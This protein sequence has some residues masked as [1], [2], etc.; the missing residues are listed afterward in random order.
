MRVRRKISRRLANYL[1]DTRI[2]KRITQT[3]LAK[4]SGYK[5]GQT[6]CAIESGRI[7]PEPQALAAYVHFCGASFDRI[8]ELQT[9]HLEDQLREDISEQIKFYQ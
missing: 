3:D 1:G 5:K 7:H 4:W 9:S 2:R 8:L 6:F